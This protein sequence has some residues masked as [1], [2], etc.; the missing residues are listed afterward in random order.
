MRRSLALAAAALLLPAAADA[1]ERA[2][3]EVSCQ[4]TDETLVY[5]CMIMLKGRSSGAPLDGAKI[6]VKADMPSMP[7]AHNVRPVTAMASDKPGM[8]R[9]RLALEMHGEWALTLDIAG[10]TRDRLIEKVMFAGAGGDGMAGH[11]SHGGRM[12]GGQ[13]AAGHAM[14][15]MARATIHKIS[16][17]G[18]GEA[19]GTITVSDTDK[20]LM[21][22]PDIKGL[23]PGE[24]GFH[25]HAVGDCGPG[26]KDG[27][28]VA[29]L[30]AGGH[31][32]HHA[33]G[34]AH[35][36]PAG[37]L[38]A[39]TVAADG[40]AT[41]PVLNPH[42]KAAEL[43]GRSIMIHAAGGPDRVACGVFEK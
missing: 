20:G 24:H 17:Q 9:A 32:G 19:V 43:A 1:A 41:K 27:K 11:G 13:M 26:E 25:I 14:P 3:A 8:Y 39:L 34:G 35:G 6:T 38:P 28:V 18:V 40:T 5:D 37:D 4:P 36:M 2:A 42:L 30:A 22:T 29:G 33:Q 12:A 7:M 16:P 31:Y 21:V 15:G 23:A 10:P